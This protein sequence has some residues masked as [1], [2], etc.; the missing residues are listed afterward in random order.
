MNQR[1]VSLLPSATEIVCAL[2]ARE[3]LVGR[4]HECDYPLDVA[5][6]PIC[7]EAKVRADGDS[8]TIH[9]SVMS[10][11]EQDISV[12]R[13]YSE[14]LRELRPS[15]IVTQVQCDV[16]AVSLRDVEAAIAEWIGDSSRIVALNPA[17]LESVWADIRHVAEAIGRPAESLVASLRRRI[18]EIAERAQSLP[19][20]PRVATIEWMSPL[21]AAGNWMPQLIELAGAINLLGKPGE[22]SPWLKWDDLVAADPD[23]ILIL[24]CGF[25]IPHT[26]RDMCFLTERPEWQELRAART[27]KVFI[28]DGNQY[29]NRPGPR[30]VE[31]LEILAEILHPEAFDF[32]HRGRGWI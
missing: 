9:A 10:V 24:P 23:V 18:A 17:S 27:G 29:F 32:G 5:A 30:L 2:G 6:L 21:M 12:Y 14:L 11:L 20:R 8:E 15:V 19:L 25:S 22:H 31:S 3:R 16:C 28:A 4:S 7:T 26:R 13:V 1:I